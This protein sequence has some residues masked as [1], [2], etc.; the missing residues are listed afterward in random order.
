MADSSTVPET[1]ED[2]SRG[3]L[4]EGGKAMKTEGLEG[5]LEAFENVMSVPM[6]YPGR[7]YGDGDRPWF[8]TG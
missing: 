6:L 5:G 2:D 4:E 8:F 3:L 1:G 7:E